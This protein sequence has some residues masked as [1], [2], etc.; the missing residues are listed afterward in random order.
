MDRLHELL[1][2]RTFQRW[3]HQKMQK[4]KKNSEGEPNKK[5]TTIRIQTTH[6]TDGTS[7][8]NQL[9]SGGSLKVFEGLELSVSQSKRVAQKVQKSKLDA[10]ELES[11]GNNLIIVVSKLNVPPFYRPQSFFGQHGIQKVRQLRQKELSAN[12]G[13][14]NIAFAINFSE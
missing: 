3:H 5:Y 2:P 12:L 11:A 8:L 1:L 9:F 6:Y 7:T 4:T 14:G 10:G 13:T